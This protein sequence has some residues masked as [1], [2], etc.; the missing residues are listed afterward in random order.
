MVCTANGSPKKKGEWAAE[1]GLFFTMYVQRIYWRKIERQ[2]L[3]KNTSCFLKYPAFEHV[4]SHYNSLL[5][6]A[7]SLP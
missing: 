7:R 5:V 3:I 2:R 6:I 1:Y 4:M